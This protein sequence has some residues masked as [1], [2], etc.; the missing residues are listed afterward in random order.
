M[1]PKGLIGI[2]KQRSANA[3]YAQGRRTF[4]LITSTLCRYFGL[5]N[6]L[7]DQLVHVLQSRYGIKREQDTIGM[8]NKRELRLSM[9]KG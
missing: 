4:A 9:L 3:T 7:R 6:N 1:K 5:D 2:A 8:F